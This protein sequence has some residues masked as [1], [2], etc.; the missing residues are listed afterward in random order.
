M[1]NAQESQSKNVHVAMIN[2]IINKNNMKN[3]SRSVIYLF[4]KKKVILYYQDETRYGQK[5]ITSG[6]WCPKGER[7]EYKNQNGFLNL[8]IY[9]SIHIETGKRF[10]LIIPTLNS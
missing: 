5:T 3:F 4:C 1:Q 7:A 9:A 2:G 6:I 8:W 10:G